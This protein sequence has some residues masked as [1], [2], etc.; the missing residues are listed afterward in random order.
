MIEL[1]N[2]TKSFKLGEGNSLTAVRGINAQIDTGEFVI[3]VGRSGSGKTT[4]LNLAAGLTH[5]TSGA[6][7]L[8]GEDL[9]KLSDQR[10]SILRNRKIGFVFQFP[11]LLPT[12]TVYENVLLPTTFV[13]NDERSAARPRALA[14]LERVGL[15]DKVSMYPRQLSAGQQQRVVI[16]RALINQPQVILADEPTSNLDEKTELEIMDLFRELHASLGL[17]IVL[18]TH[19]RQLISAGMRSIELALGQIVDRASVPA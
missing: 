9:W 1:K 15:S 8:E 16:A 14:L 11:S 2:V 12:L 10:R 19:T 18:V 17:T 7:F 4:F 3:I 13:S 5:P 6:V